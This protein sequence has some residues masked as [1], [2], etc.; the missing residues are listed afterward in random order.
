MGKSLNIIITI[1]LLSINMNAQEFIF[2]KKLDAY[3]FKSKSGKKNKAIKYY[4]ADYFKDGYC[5]VNDGKY[6]GLVDSMGI[7]TIPLKYDSIG[8]LVDNFYVVKSNQFLGIIDN[9][10]TEHYPTKALSINHHWMKQFTR[11]MFKIDAVRYIVNRATE[12]LHL[13]KVQDNVYK[14]LSELT[15]I[16]N[17]GCKNIDRKISIQC[18]HAYL[19]ELLETRFSKYNIKESVIIDFVVTKTGEIEDII[20]DKKLS[21][22]TNK[23][24]VEI[25][26][27]IDVKNI[28]TNKGE[29]VNFAYSVGVNQ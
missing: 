24:I 15:W 7:E 4:D 26:N 25:F 17:E 2:I 11:P 22:K 10:N 13:M 9:Q 23:Q 19:K 12:E 27:S 14:G 8:I 6:F 18:D 20:F 5:I 16:F 29:Y 21:S 28:P 1:L 3:I